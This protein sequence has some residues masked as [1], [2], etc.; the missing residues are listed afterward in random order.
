MGSDINASLAEELHSSYIWQSEGRPIDAVRTHFTEFLLFQGQC[1][2]TPLFVL[3]SSRR[4]FSGS[5]PSW[6]AIQHTLYVLLLPQSPCANSTF[7]QMHRARHA[8]P[9]LQHQELQSRDWNLP[10][11]RFALVL[12]SRLDI[13]GP[14][15]QAIRSITELA[16]RAS[17]RMSPQQGEYVVVP[18]Y[19]LQVANIRA[20]FPDVEILDG[21]FSLPALSQAS[22]RYV[23]RL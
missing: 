23:A 22:I 11:I 20:M 1:L 14:F 5:S 16:S 15:E 4:R 6:K 21:G 8:V 7:T 9:P 18:V 3:L 2:K 17:G 19:D 12:R 13:L 10:R